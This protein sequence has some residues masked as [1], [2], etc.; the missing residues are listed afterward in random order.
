[1]NKFLENREIR[2]EKRK[3]HNMIW[4]QRSFFST[5]LSIP[6]LFFPRVLAIPLPELEFIQSQFQNCSRT[7]NTLEWFL[8]C[9][10]RSQRNTFINKTKA[11]I[12][13]NLLQ[14]IINYKMTSFSIITCEGDMSVCCTASYYPSDIHTLVSVVLFSVPMNSVFTACQIGPQSEAAASF[15]MWNH[16]KGNCQ[17]KVTRLG[18]Q[19]L[20]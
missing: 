1:M 16:S 10:Q 20:V 14:S 7:S 17:I 13:V 3:I 18:D 15:M 9:A 5:G 11:E 8:V 6:A 2:L 12:K 4:S 19:F